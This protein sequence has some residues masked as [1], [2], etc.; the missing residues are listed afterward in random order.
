MGRANEPQSSRGRLRRPGRVDRA[1]HLSDAQV[2]A[3]VDDALGAGERGQ[4]E[5]HLAS[6]P[7]CR[8]A[9]RDL[10][11]IRLLLR[12]LPTPVP[13]RSFRLH[14][15]DARVATPR[16]R[17]AAGWAARLVPALP[18]L[19]AATA[20]VALLLLAVTA[21]DVLTRQDDP[22][23]SPRSDVSVPERETTATGTTVAVAAVLP[24]A[25]SRPRL[26]L[27]TATTVLIAAEVPTAAESTGDPAGDTSAAAGAGDRVRAAD[28]DSD[29]E[30]ATETPGPAAAAAQVAEIEADQAA[31]EDTAT[32]S[33]TGDDGEQAA[34]D[35]PAAEAAGSDTSRDERARDAAGAD[36][37]DDDAADLQGDAQRRSPATRSP[38]PTRRVTEAPPP[39]P[40]D[41]AMSEAAPVPGTPGP[42]TPSEGPSDG[43]PAPMT[44]DVVPTSTGT[45]V[46]PA[47]GSPASG[48][49]PTAEEAGGDAGD[50]QPFRVAQVALGL[51]LGAMLALLAIVRRW[52]R[53][54]KP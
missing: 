13:G 17:P 12:E 22:I 6:C 31:G 39:D 24:T 29:R 40:A 25:T 21:G 7:T 15:A 16:W 37:A 51:L 53:P 46:V 19:Q 26:A 36:A 54:F 34:D 32:V 8:D 52:D 23:Q 4:I 41:I 48:P 35:A 43:S 9:V 47:V 14:P 5:R 42:P 30:R 28:E 50:R 44:T 2:S 45:P 10:A 1:G 3:W 11:S 49:A 20:G 33:T 27:A 38:T 18:A